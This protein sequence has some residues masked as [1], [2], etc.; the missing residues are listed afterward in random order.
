MWPKYWSFSISL[1]NE[2]LVL[3]SFRINWF[4]LLAVQETLKRLLQHRYL[5]ASVLQHSIPYGATLRVVKSGPR[6]E[7]EVVMKR[8]G[9]IQDLSCRQRP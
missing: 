4:D 8:W 1:S 2:Y 6:G 5:K 3:I 7:L 9:Q